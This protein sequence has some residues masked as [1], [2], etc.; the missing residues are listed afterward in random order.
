M[1]G[2]FVG[3]AKFSA[4]LVIAVFS[5]FVLYQFASA[6]PDALQVIIEAPLSNANVTN[7]SEYT[8]NADTNETAN[9][10]TWQYQSGGWQD[11]A[12]N[13]TAGTNFTRTIA[14]NSSLIP[15][16]NYTV[17]AVADIGGLNESQAT[18]A[19]AVTFDFRAP[20][21]TIG[22]PYADGNITGN[23]TPV[24]TFNVSDQVINGV[25][26]FFNCELF[27]NN[28]GYG[29]N[30]TVGNNTDTTLQANATIATGG[31]NVAVNCTDYA[32]NEG[33]STSRYVTIDA[34][35][36]LM[37][38]TVP[39]DNKN[40]TNAAVNFSFTPTDNQDASFTCNLTANNTYINTTNA[41]NN[42]L[43][44]FVNTLGEGY[45]NWYITCWDNSSNSNTTATRVLIV[46]TTAP[47]V[48]LSVS[49]SSIHQSESI[50]I[51]CA[52]SD[53]LSG[54]ANTSLPSVTKPTG[55]PVS[56]SCNS[57]FTDTTE[58]G[59]YS[60]SYSATDD[61]SNTGTAS[62]SFSVVG[63]GGGSGGS[64]SSSAN[65]YSKT[66]DS[67]TPGITSE[68]TISKSDLP[69]TGLTLD[70]KE[71]IQSAKI[72][73][74]KLASKPS[75]VS[76]LDNVIVYDYI[77]I[78]ATKL[79]E[80]NIEKAKLTFKI[81]KEWV[82]DHNANKD[83]V[84]LYRYENNKWNALSTSFEKEEGKYYYYESETPGFS[85]FMISSGTGVGE[86]CTPDDKRCYHY[87]LEECNEEGTAWLVS[88]KCKY[89]C[90]SETLACVK[91]PEICT[92]EAMRCVG[93]DAEQCSYRGD[94]WIPLGVCDF[95]CQNR[96]CN[97]SPYSATPFVI[98]IV[99]AILSALI[100]VFRGK[101]FALF[102][103]NQKK[104]IFK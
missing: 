97:E 93:N 15:D 47:S 24:F 8:F 14:I 74:T 19:T 28:T 102:N 46:D 66:W 101:I 98:I 44:I 64:G 82:S 70:V 25:Y 85:Y 94:L 84:V 29:T 77:E 95:G 51:S 81:T 33:E 32:G 75:G 71:A 9:N 76:I 17:R 50:L 27:F 52:T 35:D 2:L 43:A 16:G 53:S 18:N 48:S 61:A 22:A 59:T 49:V 20:T 92:P 91:E 62:T 54:V 104:T 21:I 67:L 26:S 39:A 34:I 30:T 90:D 4:I 78:V 55:A 40:T 88:E 89:K 13:T 87:D 37:T 41:L 68:S 100:F 56:A 7:T 38:I 65:T 103:K 3:K 96:E 63:G 5:F 80:S 73:M 10:L 1:N 72:T 31:Y 23:T 57:Y 86:F 58:V 36:V 6:N 45:W 83:N 79:D 11:I 99:A 12:I 60:V 69:I 42:T